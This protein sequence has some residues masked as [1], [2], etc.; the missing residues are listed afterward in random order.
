MIKGEKYR[1]TVL[2]ESLFRLEYSE[3]GVFVDEPTQTVLCRDFPKVNYKLND[4]DEYL[5]IITSN[6][7]LYYNKKDLKSVGYA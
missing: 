7:K 5:E 2:T 6:A 4:E 1:I 3:E